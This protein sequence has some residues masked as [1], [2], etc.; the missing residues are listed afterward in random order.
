MKNDKRVLIL[1]DEETFRFLK[2]EAF[3]TQQSMGELCRNAIRLF[4]NDELKIKK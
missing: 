2:K 1:V 3:E 4:Y